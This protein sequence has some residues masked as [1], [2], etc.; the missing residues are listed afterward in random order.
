MDEQ[1]PTQQRGI[2]TLRN[3]FGAKCIV[4]SEGYLFLN[5][6]TIIFYYSIGGISSLWRYVCKNCVAIQLWPCRAL[7]DNNPCVIG[8][9]Y[10]EHLPATLK[11]EPYDETFKHQLKDFFMKNLIHFVF[12]F[13]NRIE[14][15]YCHNTEIHEKKK[16]M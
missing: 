2:L 7:A 14:C 16:K 3:K 1:S 6:T 10:Y 13:S 5:Q 12:L 9:T 11:R 15:I 4:L 8:P